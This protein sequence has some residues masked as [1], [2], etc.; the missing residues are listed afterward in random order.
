MG[1]G[2]RIMVYKV[3]FLMGYTLLVLLWVL[4]TNGVYFFG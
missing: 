3:L 2:M 1:K 4:S